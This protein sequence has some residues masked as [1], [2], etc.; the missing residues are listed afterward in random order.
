MSYAYDKLNPDKGGTLTGQW[1]GYEEQFYPSLTSWQTKAGGYRA[2][3]AL[4]RDVHVRKADGTVEVRRE[5]IPVTDAEATFAPEAFGLGPVVPRW[6]ASF[7]VTKET[8]GSRRTLPVGMIDYRITNNWGMGGGVV[9][10]NPFVAV[11][12]RFGK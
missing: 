7:G 12:Y 11:S 6:T 4:H 3:F 1:L 2:A 10:T 5:A 8:A 9:G